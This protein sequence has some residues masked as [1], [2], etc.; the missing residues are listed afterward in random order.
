MP[1]N[2]IYKDI[3]VAPSSQS[4]LLEFSAT[5]DD[6]D[7]TLS[8]GDLQTDPI[9]FDADASDV[10]DALRVLG[11]PLSLVV[12][13]GSYA[14]GFTVVMNDIADSLV[15]SSNTLEEMSN[16][17]TTTVTTSR[18]YV[19]DTTTYANAFMQINYGALSGPFDLSIEVS[20]TLEDSDFTVDSDT[21]TALDEA[22]G[23]LQFS[24]ENM[25]MKYI[26]IVAPDTENDFI[27]RNQPA[28]FGL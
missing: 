27:I 13:S 22:G 24:L 25:F 26:R 3:I 28:R 20:A 5:P 18:T 9:P 1:F 10:Q 11:E 19:L 15:V 7:M 14:A 17:I 6:G 2:K 4:A 21:T 12:V 8:V 23:V 16:P